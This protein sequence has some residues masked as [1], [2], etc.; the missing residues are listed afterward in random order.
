MPSKAGSNHIK[1]MVAQSYL[2][3]PFPATTNRRIKLPTRFVPMDSPGYMTF[4][5]TRFTGTYR[6]NSLTSVGVRKISSSK[7]VKPEG[8]TGRSNKPSLIFLT[9]VSSTH[10]SGFFVTSLTRT[11]CLISLN[12]KNKRNVT[13]PSHNPSSV[14][15]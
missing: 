6:K 10:F 13:Y 9:G 12:L 5:C 2:F 1:N 14:T 11:N 8:F 4:S 15:K 7:R 3:F